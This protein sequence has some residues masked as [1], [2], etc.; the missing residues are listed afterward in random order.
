MG[1][2]KNPHVNF[3]QNREQFLVN[4]C[5][6]KVVLHLGCADALYL[7]DQ[8]ENERHLHLMIK[9]VAQELYG[10]DINEKAI[11]KLSGLDVSNLYCGDLERL[12]INFQTNFDI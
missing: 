1:L 5:R 8:L 9:N 12:D 3:V 6:G 10:V 11:Q 4:L 7:E 2:K